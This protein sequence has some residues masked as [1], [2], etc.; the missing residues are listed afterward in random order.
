M[1]E[2]P[3]DGD[4]LFSYAQ[5]IQQTQ[6]LCLYASSFIDNKIR[7]DHK[8]IAHYDKEN[9]LEQDT[10]PLSFT[11]ANDVEERFAAWRDT[12]GLESTEVGIFEHNIQAYQIGK[13]NYTLA[14]D[15]K[16]VD[17]TDKRVN[18]MTSAQ[19]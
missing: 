14:D 3:T 17:A 18:T 2:D 16:A 11:K 1:A 6:Y 5:Q 7:F 15:T 10:T 13:N 12:Y 4:Q 8:I 19:F 9:I